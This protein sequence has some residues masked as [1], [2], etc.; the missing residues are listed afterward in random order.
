MD[1]NVVNLV[2]MHVLIM[3]LSSCL[4]RYAQVDKYGNCYDICY[5]GIVCK[6]MFVAQ[7]FKASA[8]RK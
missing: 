6:Y 3:L 2:T 4:S 1:I 7:F 8:L 5:I